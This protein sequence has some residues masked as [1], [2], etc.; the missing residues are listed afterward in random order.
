MGPHTCLS[1][2]SFHNGAE[3]EYGTIS[4]LLT[5]LIA[6]GD[7]GDT[8]REKLEYRIKKALE[9]HAFHEIRDLSL[10]FDGE[11]LGGGKTYP[12]VGVTAAA[13]ASLNRIRLR[14]PSESMLSP[15][16]P[17]VSELTHFKATCQY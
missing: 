3:Y 12:I 16:G 8:Q 11:P 15:R 4:P 9:R 1:S 6:A 13:S 17:S 14:D 2:T 5:V 7:Q 10:G